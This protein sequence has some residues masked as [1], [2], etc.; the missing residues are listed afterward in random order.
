MSAEDIEDG[1]ETPGPA[2][3]EGENTEV[4]VIPPT[5]DTPPEESLP[6]PPPPT[7]E[8]DPGPPPAPVPGPDP[9]NPWG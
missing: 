1:D 7:P 3:T 5:V 2:P 4:G 6:P 9:A 8:P